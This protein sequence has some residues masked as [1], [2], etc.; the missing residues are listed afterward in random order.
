MV[1]YD[2]W[3][4]DYTGT[5]VRDN[6][7]L[8]GFATDNDNATMSKGSNFENAIIKYAKLLPLVFAWPN[9]LFLG[10]GLLLD[11]ALGSAINLEAMS[12]STASFRITHFLAHSATVLRRHLPETSLFQAML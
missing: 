5:V 7:I 9:L 8:G 3:N 1:D 6:L 4:G 12:T 11:P 2:P 10:S